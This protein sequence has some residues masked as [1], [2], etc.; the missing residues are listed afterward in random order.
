MAQAFYLTD[1]VVPMIPQRLS[2]G[3]CSA[4]THMFHGLTMR[5]LQM[6]LH[7]KEKLFRNEIFQSVIQTTERMTHTALK[8][9]GKFLEG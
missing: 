2:N 7:Q 8:I 3:I 9:N 4:K 5:E 6:K 1:R